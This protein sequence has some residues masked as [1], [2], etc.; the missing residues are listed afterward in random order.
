MF[1][2]TTTA[3]APGLYCRALRPGLTLRCSDRA[4]SHD[5]AS[6]AQAEAGLHLVLM[7]DGQIDLAY[8]PRALCLGPALS[9]DVL[10]VHLAEPEGFRRAAQ[11]LAMGAERKLSIELG[12]GWLQESGLEPRSRTSTP[13]LQM[14]QGRASRHQRQIGQALLRALPQADALTGLRVESLVLE[15][16]G[17][18]LAPP[19]RASAQSA[20]ERVARAPE[21][22]DSGAA[23]GWTLADIALELGVHVNTLQRLFREQQ[24]CSVFDYLRR[25][26]LQRAR[27]LLLQGLSVTEAALEAGYG[28]PA[29]FSTA[30]KREFGHSPG[31]L[32]GDK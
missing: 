24:G 7:L 10:M 1:A 12:C 3:P 13:H 30:F 29:N 18:L 4:H 17:E 15:L 26:R 16:L 27:L 5:G 8:G 31:Q 28:S 2:R 9:S 11:E 19:A 20:A 14:R 6:E 23:D 21:L 22:L 32:C 25:C